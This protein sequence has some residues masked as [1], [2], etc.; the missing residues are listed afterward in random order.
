MSVEAL[1]PVIKGILTAPDVDLRTI[2][3]KRV[4]K[5]ILQQDPSLSETWIRDNKD[6]IDKLIASIFGEVAAAQAEAV[7]T[8]E[9][10]ATTNGK[11]KHEEIEDGPF[12][13]PEKPISTP[14]Q[15]PAPS[16]TPSKPPPKKTEKNADEDYARQL[17]AELN[18][19]R[20]R[21]SGADTSKRPTKKAKSKKK[22]A[23]QVGSD[24]DGD[25]PPKKKA[26]GG[27]QK[28]YILSEALANLVQAPKMSRPQVVKQ[29]WNHIKGSNLQ[30]P[31]N[32]KEIIC[33]DGMKAVFGVERI[34]MFQ[35][36]KQLGNHLYDEHER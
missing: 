28:E 17:A 15:A 34:D 7:S 4:R 13:S 29:L 19:H 5:Q 31:L 8:A 36:N 6:D 2:S 27:F 21:S 3:A 12:S 23:A 35:M 11:R 1:T 18:S 33:D 10:A 26:K 25:E 22:S 14:R 30:D 24:E 32:R 9:A 16:P 20:T